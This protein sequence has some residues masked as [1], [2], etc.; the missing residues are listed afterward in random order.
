MLCQGH[1]PRARYFTTKSRAMLPVAVLIGRYCEGK[2]P[3]YVGAHVQVKY[4]YQQPNTSVFHKYQN[5]LI[6]T[7]GLDYFSCKNILLTGILSSNFCQTHSGPSITL[8]KK[9]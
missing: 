5:N 2:N 4:K 9:R 8:Q 6:T 1:I 7:I 3:V